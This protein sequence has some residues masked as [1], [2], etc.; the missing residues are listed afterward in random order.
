MCSLLLRV[1]T[2]WEE[3][4][5]QLEATSAKNCSIRRPS[6]ARQN[7]ATAI[8]NET[9]DSRSSWFATSSMWGSAKV[10]DN[11]PHCLGAEQASPTKQ[12]VLVFQNQR[13]RN[14]DVELPRAHPIEDGKRR[15]SS[16]PNCRDEYVRVE[17]SQW[18]ACTRLTPVV[19][20]NAIRKRGPRRASLRASSA[21]SSRS[22]IPRRSSGSGSLRHLAREDHGDQLSP[23]ACDIVTGTATSSRRVPQCDM[24]V[25]KVDVPANVPV[26]GCDRVS[27]HGRSCSALAPFS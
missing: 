17:N 4:L 3:Y 9:H 23:V 12:C 2:S 13:D 8:P 18:P 15:A 24:P 27:C 21:I 14:S 1:S 11:V 20:H 26:W 22:R 5:Q 7:G 25:F 6:G 10:V 19:R 16:G